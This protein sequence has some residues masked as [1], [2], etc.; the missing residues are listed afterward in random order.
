MIKK[1]KKVRAQCQSG[2]EGKSTSIC[3]NQEE[4]HKVGD[5]GSGF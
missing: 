3:G 4:F 5:C 2:P 1:K